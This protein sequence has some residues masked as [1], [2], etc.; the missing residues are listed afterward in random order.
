MQWNSIACI[1]YS[2]NRE[3]RTGYTD[4]LIKEYIPLE[5]GYLKHNGWNAQ[6]LL[7]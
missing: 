6:G 1:L 5:T 4:W 2:A 7:S 3:A